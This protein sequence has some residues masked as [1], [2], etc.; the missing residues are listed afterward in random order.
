METS[1]CLQRHWAVFSA[2]P[3]VSGPLLL[4]SKLSTLLAWPTDTCGFHLAHTLPLPNHSVSALSTP[5]CSLSYPGHTCIWTAWVLRATVEQPFPKHGEGL[6]V[7]PLVLCEVLARG[8]DREEVRSHCSIHLCDGTW[9]W[10]EGQGWGQAWW[11]HKAQKSCTGGC[12]L[13]H[14]QG[15]AF[16]TLSGYSLVESTHTPRSRHACPKT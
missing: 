5:Q 10:E 2:P 7:Q 1:V 8:E 3:G 16:P 11:T 14:G 12:E 9:L 4:V 15:P 6:H 13:H